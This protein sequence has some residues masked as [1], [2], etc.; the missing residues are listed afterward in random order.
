MTVATVSLIMYFEIPYSQQSTFWQPL[1]CVPSTKLNLPIIPESAYASALKEYK[2]INETDSEGNSV[3][4]PELFPY[5]N[6]TA[7]GS[8]SYYFSPPVF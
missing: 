6:C 1:H 5:A 8:V 7:S 3:L 2:D 4:A